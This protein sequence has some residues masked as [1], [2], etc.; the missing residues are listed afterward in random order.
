MVKN[1]ER[2]KEEERFI[3]LWFSFH[4]LFGAW[5]LIGMTM[6]CNHCDVMNI[7]WHKTEM[8]QKSDR[9]RWG[10]GEGRERER[11]R[12][13]VLSFEYGFMRERK[14]KLVLDPTLEKK[15]G[16]LSS[17]FKHPRRWMGKPEYPG[18]NPLV[19]CSAN[20]M[21]LILMRV[22]LPPKLKKTTKERERDA[23]IL[24]HAYIY[25]T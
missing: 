23:H 6:T 13:S 21:I 20:P 7:M 8:E 22:S 5:K 9:K 10:D 3:L 24:S 2:K 25:M 14:K 12:E 19:R 17:Y 4:S 18:E 15:E 1:D 11:E 16:F